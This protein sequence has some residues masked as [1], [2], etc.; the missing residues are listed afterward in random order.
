MKSDNEDFE[1]IREL[2]GV[3]EAHKLVKVFRGSLVYIPK[4]DLIIERH[5]SIKQEFGDGA[6]YNELAIKYGYTKDYIRKIVHKRK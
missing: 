6:N 3:E 5:Q 2:I 1:L 4:S